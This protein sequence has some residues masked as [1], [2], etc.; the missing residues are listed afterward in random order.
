MS[1]I[2]RKTLKE[3]QKSKGRTNWEQVD[4]ISEE[5]LEEVV[6]H[7]PDDVYLT[8]EEL[9]QGKW[10]HHVQ[11]PQ[12]KAAISL[13]IDEDVLKFFKSQGRGYQT[14]MNNVLRAYMESIR[15]KRA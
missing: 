3:A 5:E 15:R 13:R 12:H 1:K 11:E 7:D 6:K 10:V 8:D 2:I 14:R 9:K 4:A